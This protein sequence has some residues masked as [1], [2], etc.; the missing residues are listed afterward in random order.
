MSQSAL[1][2]WLPP[3]FLLRH[4]G[5]DT[6]AG[7]LLAPKADAAAILAK[8]YFAFLFPQAKKCRPAKP[9]ADESRKKPINGE[10]IK[11]A[12]ARGGGPSE[13]IEGQLISIFGRPLETMFKLAQ[14]KLTKTKTE[15]TS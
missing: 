3:T 8:I 7:H 2:L 13:P 1:E 15:L 14:N 9:A 4:T 6:Q 12:T 10:A 5:V 11:L